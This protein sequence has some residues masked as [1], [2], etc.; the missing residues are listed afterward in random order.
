MHI[1]AFL[2]RRLFQA[3]VVMLIISVIGFSF[4]S[5]THC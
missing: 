3:V 5:M 2:I 4:A 1:L